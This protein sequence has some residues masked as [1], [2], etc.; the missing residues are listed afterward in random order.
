MKLVRRGRDGVVSW[1]CDPGLAL[2]PR[3][4]SSYRRLFCCN[5]VCKGFT[6]LFPNLQGWEL[7]QENPCQYRL[8]SAYVKSTLILQKGVGICGR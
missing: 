5:P 4:D 2:R 1:A 3:F 8:H 6:V 7:N